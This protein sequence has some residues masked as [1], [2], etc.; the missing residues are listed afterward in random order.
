MTSASSAILI[1]IPALIC[2]KY[3]ARL[4]SNYHL[5]D[6]QYGPRCREKES[7]HVD[8]GI[9][10]CVPRQRVHDNA[11]CLR[12]REQLVVD[13]VRILDRLVLGRAR[14]PLLLYPR[15]VQHVRAANDAR[16]TRRLEDGN[17]SLDRLSLDALGHGERGGRDKVEGDRV[18]GEKADERVDRAAVLEISDHRDRETVDG[19]ELLSDRVNVEEGL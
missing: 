15:H 14:E 16:E 5:I 2:L 19:S 3:A 12:T 18:E 8:F 6:C 10:L 9:E 4:R 11:V 17:A 1:H 7:A 13:N